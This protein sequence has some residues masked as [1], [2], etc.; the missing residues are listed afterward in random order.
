MS[1]STARR[2]AART[3]AAVAATG[4]LTLSAGVAAHADTPTIVTPGS[5]VCIKAPAATGAHTA[6][7]ASN[8][9]ATFS[10]FRNGTV[11]YFTT[12]NT[13]GFAADFTGAGT[14]KVCATNSNSTNTKVTLTLL[15]Y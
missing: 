2:T 14:Y 9:G 1:I 5:T 8:Q 7:T 15:P 6:G 10:V 4:A 11:V 3:L 12:P 13:I